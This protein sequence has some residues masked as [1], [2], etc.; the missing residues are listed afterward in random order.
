MRTKKEIF[1]DTINLRGIPFAFIG[2]RVELN[3]KR[4]NIRGVNSSTNLEVLFD[5]EKNKIIC[6]PTWEMVYFNG[7]GSICKDFRESK[8]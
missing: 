8:V 7:D 2:M 4:G 5:N 1:N 6:H 3:G